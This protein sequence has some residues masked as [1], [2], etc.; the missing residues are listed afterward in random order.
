MVNIRNIIMVTQEEYLKNRQKK[1]MVVTIWDAGYQDDI[2][3]DELIERI[4]KNKENLLRNG[5]GVEESSIVI[6]ICNADEDYPQ[7]DINWEQ[8]ETMEE[9]EKR[10]EREQIY[11]DNRIRRLQIEISSN[12]EEAA[13]YVD[14]LR[15]K[16]KKRNE[17][18]D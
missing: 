8:W 12:F 14:L 16:M 9:Y 11:H 4:K 15:K 13:A 3:P 18:K 5:M 7:L 1:S 17:N 10:K 2:S 6:N